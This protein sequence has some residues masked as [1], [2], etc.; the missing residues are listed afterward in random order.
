MPLNLAQIENEDGSM[1]PQQ[2]NNFPIGE[3]FEKVMGLKIAQGRDL[4]SRLLTDVGSNMLVNE[5]LVKKMGWTDPLGKRIQLGGNNGRVVGVVQDFNFKSLR[6]ID[7]TGGHGSR[8][9]RTLSQDQ[10]D[11][12]AFPAGS[13]DAG[14]CSPTTSARPFPTSRR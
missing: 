11:Q 7:R 14:R 4:S 12:Q 8:S 6:T 13:S 2:F 3:D 10:R 1:A 5:S 9:T